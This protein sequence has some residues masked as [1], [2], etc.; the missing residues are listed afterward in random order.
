MGDD[1]YFLPPS[2]LFFLL[3]NSGTKLHL[4]LNHQLIYIGM[5]HEKLP[6]LQRA[7]I[8]A[9]LDG[10]EALQQLLP[11]SKV[12]LTAMDQNQDPLI[13]GCL[14]EIFSLGVPAYRLRF[15]APVHQDTVQRRFQTLRETVF[16][17]ASKEWSVLVSQIEMDETM[18]DGK[19]PGVQD[20]SA[21]VKHTAFGLYQV[22]GKVLTFHVASSNTRELVPL[23][24]QLTKADSLYY[25]DEWHAYAALRM[26]DNHVTMDYHKGLG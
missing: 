13:W 5:R 24:T 12:Q 3:G 10:T 9:T 19:V 14:V 18:F 26:R 2:L 20:W 17:Q 6:S 7:D 4:V 8:M 11:G 1:P 25:T 16:Q 15:Q 21:S 22:S 23:L